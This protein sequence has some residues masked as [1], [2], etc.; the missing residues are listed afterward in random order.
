VEVK[1]I[2]PTV[3]GTTAVLRMTTGSFIRG[4]EQSADRIT[5]KFF[6]VFTPEIPVSVLFGLWPMSVAAEAARVSSDAIT[7][8][9]TKDAKTASWGSDFYPVAILQQNQ[10]DTVM[11]R[12][13]SPVEVRQ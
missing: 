11:V 9:L 4:Y 8:D 10:C 3:R 12:F 2:L 6:G 7:V 13:E 1:V 5:L